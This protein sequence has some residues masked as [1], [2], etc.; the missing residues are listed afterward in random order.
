MDPPPGQMVSERVMAAELEQRAV[1]SAA[2][3]DVDTAAADYWVHMSVVP[4]TGALG[5][6]DGCAGSAAS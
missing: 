4:S 5:G 1:D 3:A 2:A 6:G